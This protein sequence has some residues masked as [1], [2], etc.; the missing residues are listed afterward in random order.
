MDLLAEEALKEGLPSTPEDAI[1]AVVTYDRGGIRR[2]LAETLAR[3]IGGLQRFP[4]E[5][6]IVAHNKGAGGVRGRLVLDREGL[7]DLRRRKAKVYFLTD[8]LETESYL[9]RMAKTARQP[10]HGLRIVRFSAVVKRD[11]GIRRVIL[12]RVGEELPL[13]YFLD[14]QLDPRQSAEDGDAVQHEID[15]AFEPATL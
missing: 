13:V 5:P 11:R 15:R 14:C 7:R 1:A 10:R 6:F 3:K 4:C 9:I 8:L 12:D 2:T